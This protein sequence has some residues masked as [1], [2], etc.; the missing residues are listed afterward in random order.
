M[1]WEKRWRHTAVHRKRWRRLQT[2]YQEWP[3][4]RTLIDNAQISLVKADMGIARLYAGLVE[5]AALR[6]RVFGQIAASYD[7]TCHWI[8]QVTGQREI[9]G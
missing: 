3:F 4:F 5:D 7:L 6:Q 8:L 9:A 2:M 1:D